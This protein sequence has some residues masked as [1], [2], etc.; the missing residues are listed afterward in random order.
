MSFVF[1]RFAKRFVFFFFSCWARRPMGVLLHHFTK[2]VALPT[3]SLPW[4]GP[5]ATEQMPRIRI[6]FWIECKVLQGPWGCLAQPWVRLALPAGEAGLGVCSGVAQE[7]S[8]VVFQVTLG[9][10]PGVLRKATASLLFYAACCDAP[11]ETEQ[12]NQPESLSPSGCRFHV[13]A[14]VD[15]VQSKRRGNSTTIPV[16][17]T[18]E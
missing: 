2:K 14:R 13:W 10:E 3:P 7:N 11:F 6:V 8:R 1:V 15:D 16:V 5:K 12:G 4:P 9:T 18:L 17:S